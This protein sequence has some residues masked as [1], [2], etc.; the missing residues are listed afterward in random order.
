M[1]VIDTMMKLAPASDGG[2]PRPLYI[3]KVTISES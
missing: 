1:N 3:Y 2:P